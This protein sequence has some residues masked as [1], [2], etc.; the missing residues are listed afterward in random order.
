VRSAR[1]HGAQAE[2]YDPYSKEFGDVSVLDSRYDFVT[3]QDVLE[4]VEDPHDLVA[5][6]KS[7]AVLGGYIAIDTPNADSIDLHDPRN[8]GYLSQLHHRHISSATE[9]QRMASDGGWEVIEFRKSPHVD[10]RI[11][12][13]N[14]AFADYF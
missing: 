4:Q 9:L 11:P 1:E 3:A 2:S 10:T 7:Y 6:L 14:S 13:L 8:L 12:S 5:D